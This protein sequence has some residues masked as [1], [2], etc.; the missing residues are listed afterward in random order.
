MNK[1]DFAVCRIKEKLPE[2]QGF[3]TKGGG[4]VVYCERL[5]TSWGWKCPYA[6]VTP[7]VVLC[8]NDLASG[9]IFVAE[10]LGKDKKGLEAFEMKQMSEVCK[11]V[12][13]RSLDQLQPDL[14]LTFLS[15][16]PL[17]KRGF[18]KKMVKK[19]SLQTFRPLDC[20][21]IEKKSVEESTE[22]LFCRVI[23]DLFSESTGNKPFSTETFKVVYESQTKRF[24]LQ[25]F[26]GYQKTFNQEMPPI[27]AVIFTNKGEFAGLLRNFSDTRVT[28]VFL[29][30]PWMKDDGIG[31]VIKLPNSG[32]GVC[33]TEI[34]GSSAGMQVLESNLRP[35]SHGS[36]DHLCEEKSLDNDNEDVIVSGDVI[37][38]EQNKLPSSDVVAM[39][40][41]LMNAPLVQENNNLDHIEETVNTDKALASLKGLEQNQPFPQNSIPANRNDRIITEGVLISANNYYSNDHENVTEG[42]DSKSPDVTKKSFHKTEECF[43]D[44]VKASDQTGGGVEAD[45]DLCRTETGLNA[46]E[47]TP[48]VTSVGPNEADEDLEITKITLDGTYIASDWTILTL[49]ETEGIPKRD[50]D[51]ERAEDVSGRTEEAFDEIEGALEKKTEVPGKTE[52]LPGEEDIAPNETGQAVDGIK[53]VLDETKLPPGKEEEAPGEIKLTIVERGDAVEYVDHVQNL[54]DVSPDA[55]QKG[56]VGNEVATNK[57]Q[58][59]V[60][61][62]EVFPG[63]GTED[64]SDDL[65]VL[66]KKTEEMSYKSEVSPGDTNKSPAKTKEVLEWTGESQEQAE[67][68]NNTGELFVKVDSGSL[69]SEKGRPNGTAGSPE[70]TEVPNNTGELF[71]MVDSGLPCSEEGRPNGTAGSPEQTEVPNNTGE[72]FVKVD[73]GSLSCEEGGP[74]GTAGSQERTEVPNNT[75]ELFAMVNSGLPC[76]EE[77]RPNGT[78]EYPEWTEVHNN[79]GELFAMVD[80]G[81]PCSEEGRPNGT[82]GSPERNEVPNNTGELFAM[83]DSGLPCSEEGRPNGTAEYPEQT[84]V[85]NNTGEFFAMVDSGPPFSEEGRPNGTAESPERNEVPNNTGELFAMVDSGLPCSEEGRPNGTGQVTNEMEVTAQEVDTGLLSG[86][87]GHVNRVV[88]SE[89]IVRSDETTKVPFQ[90]AE[91]PGQ[92]EGGVFVKEGDPDKVRHSSEEGLCEV[93]RCNGNLMTTMKQMNIEEVFRGC[94]PQKEDLQMTDTLVDQESGIADNN[95]IVSKLTVSETT[96]LVGTKPYFGITVPVVSDHVT[97]DTEKEL[98]RDDEF[99]AVSKDSKDLTEH[100]ERQN[101]EL[102][103]QAQTDSMVESLVSLECFKDK[104]VGLHSSE[105]IEIGVREQ[106]NLNLKQNDIAISEVKD[107]KGNAKTDSCEELLPQ[108]SQECDQIESSDHDGAFTLKENLGV[109]G[110]WSSGAEVH[111][112]SD[113]NLVSLEEETGEISQDKSKI[114][115]YDQSAQNSDSRDFF[116]SVNVNQ[117]GWH[118][119][120]STNPAADFE[121][122]SS[123]NNEDVQVGELRLLNGNAVLQH[124][125]ADA[126]L[127]ETVTSNPLILGDLAHCLDT[128]Y[129]YGMVPCWRDLAELLAIPREVYRDC[130][131]LSITSPT[132]DLFV[133]LSATKPQLTIAEIKEAL[134]E[135]DRLDVAQLLERRIT[136]GVI[137][138]E[139]VVTS[140]VERQDLDILG[141]MALKLDR[142]MLQNW[143]H[144]ALQLSVPHRVLRNLGPCQQYNSSKM[145][146]KY[147]PVFDPELTL[148]KLKASFSTVGLRDA[149]AVLE[150]AGIPGDQPIKNILDDSAFVDQIAEVLNDDPPS[151]NWR[152]LARELKIPVDK[153]KVFEPTEDNSSPTRLLFK[154]I[155]KCEPDLTFEELVLALVAMKRQDV[156]DILQKYFSS[157]DIDQILEENNLLVPMEPDEKQDN[158][159]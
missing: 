120:Q 75:G 29:P 7:S 74:N 53:E 16:E 60:D 71:A 54:I 124:V 116:S 50:E 56:T 10:F 140:L 76:S 44:T 152:H 81:L 36:A 42:M 89:L 156:L 119:T 121:Q 131:T 114:L 19:G 39:E 80:S 88:D 3:A 55:T 87:A 150:S 40:S 57:T 38:Q 153:W 96:E 148:D 91:D 65:L 26:G 102:E 118:I 6:I 151:P 126:L 27:G 21:F 25:D 15:V 123:V 100:Q 135:I 143:K 64:G 125:D 149:V 137:S 145:L 111:K 58:G 13:G 98:L 138:N 103:N 128:E 154:S 79:T 101:F 43:D 47:V 132:E 84:E 5:A 14:Y 159:E 93:M 20:Y 45:S 157:D 35:K 4:C 37:F 78:A 99:T 41:G 59:S 70:Q 31:E 108:S 48:H 83:V 105:K 67:V 155:A 158:T 23:S 117:S 61:G 24:S 52:V 49:G 33:Q 127:S 11:D 28:P 2:P 134:T 72:L 122:N 46:T 8:Q 106:H 1:V 69:S 107:F 133:F 113:P 146:L 32:N 147:I 129:Q 73:S 66:P 82:A 115:A 22:G 12:V 9:K 68:P 51:H 97:P 18:L 85:P 90:P 139:S 94:S 30:E 62:T 141:K 110:D 109:A 136:G 92:V 144:L 104:T 112:V 34:P 17:D 130:G 77:G 142:K 63:N 95:I 86:F